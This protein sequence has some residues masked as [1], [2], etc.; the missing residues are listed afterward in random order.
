MDIG[1]LN[2]CEIAEGNL[3]MCHEF[4]EFDLAVFEYNCGLFLPKFVNL[5]IVRLFESNDA[6]DC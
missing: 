2:A 1:Y 6:N 5:A 4:A 3:E